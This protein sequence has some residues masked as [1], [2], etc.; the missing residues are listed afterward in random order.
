MLQQTLL[1]TEIGVNIQAI[2]SPIITQI[3]EIQ[4]SNIKMAMLYLISL[5]EQKFQK[6]NKM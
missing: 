2:N 1:P 3:I 6:S 4:N 5:S